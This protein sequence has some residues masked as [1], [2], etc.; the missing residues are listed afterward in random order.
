MTSRPRQPRQH[1]G[2][3]GA[4]SPAQLA[5]RRRQ[6][7]EVR[8]VDYTQIPSREAQQRAREQLEAGEQNPSAAPKPGPRKPQRFELVPNPSAAPDDAVVTLNPSDPRPCTRP[9]R[10]IEREIR[11]LSGTS[12][13][14]ITHDTVV[15]T[16]AD[17]E[18]VWTADNGAS[19]HFLR[20]QWTV[21]V[22]RADNHVI[23]VLPSRYALSV[24]PEEFEAEAPID[25]S[26]PSNRRK[27]GTRH[28]ADLRELR[29]RLKAHGF[30]VSTSGPTHGKV[31]HPDFPGLFTP[32][33]ST[34]SDRRHPQM[35][36]AQVKRVF[37]IDI[38]G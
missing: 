34:P 14:V 10:V 27:K 21:Q 8:P 32:W 9:L 19:D 35:V 16:V 11:L 18:E 25:V 33:A 36:T 7:A 15:M 4:P 2:S 37:G 13:A 3:P 17:P 28:P 20:G 26:G 24:R 31:T 12:L 29:L 1:P 38:R 30:R 23:A 6:A 5:G 22:R